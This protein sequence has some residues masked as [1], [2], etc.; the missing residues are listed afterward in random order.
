MK[1]AR[2]FF[3]KHEDEPTTEVAIR[4]GARRGPLHRAGR[5]R[6]GDADG[7]LRGHRQPA[8]QLD[9]AWASASWR[10]AR[11]SRCC[12]S[13]R[14]RSR[15]RSCRPARRRRRCCSCCCC[16]RGL[17]HAQHVENA[18]AVPV[19][20]THASSSGS[21]RARSS[22]CAARAA[23]SGSASA[24][25]AWPPRCARKSPRLVRRE[26]ARAD[27]RVLHREVRQP[28]AARLADRQ[29][30]QPARLVRSRISSAP[31]APR[32]CY[33]RPALVAPPAGLAGQSPAGV[34]RQI[35]PS[36]APGR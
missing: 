24:P 25:A 27:L 17:R 30:L 3:S 4:R 13:A 29:R 31:P 8:G 10:S 33:G 34:R 22:A 14:S 23:A 32:H 28:G 2:W 18:Q 15:W 26:D 1:P 21:C 20:P 12:R 16:F 7:D 11:A 36:S 6:R 19:I 9:L 5:L 35:R